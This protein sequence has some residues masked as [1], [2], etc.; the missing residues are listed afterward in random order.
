MIKACPICNNDFTISPSRVGK[1]HT[2]SNKCR[3]IYKHFAYLN[4]VDGGFFKPGHSCSNSGRTHFHKGHKPSDLSII[5]AREAWNKK[6]KGKPKPERQ[7]ANCHLW[8]GGITPINHAIRTSI[9]FVN[10]RREVFE[11]DNYT[12]QDC[13]ARNGDGKTHTLHAHH[14]KPFSK[15]PKL[16]F[17]VSN[18]KTLCK[19]CHI[20]GEHHGKRS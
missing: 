14:I 3:N 12:C 20:K 4:G 11:R 7:G 19:N 16:R 13:G 17:E 6:Y 10:W 1:R 2:C 18:G 9:C 5:K 15:Y 8:K